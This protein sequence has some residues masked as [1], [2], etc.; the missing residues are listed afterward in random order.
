M[1]ERVHAVW[2]NA[3]LFNKISVPKNLSCNII[4]KSTLTGLRE[5]KKGHYQET[6]DLMD[7]S[8]KMAEKHYYMQQ[9]VKFSAKANEVF[10]SHFYGLETISPSKAP[11]TPKK[12][13][14]EKEIN[15]IKCVFS[16]DLVLNYVSL[17]EVNGKKMRFNAIQA[18]PKQ[19]YDKVW[20]MV[21]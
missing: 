10:R 20:S 4:R 13:W 11:T 9:K 17:T 3:G 14:N 7:H 21:R 8:M 1:L 16:E 15:E 18:S 6:A 5:H 12:K 2:Y 19:I